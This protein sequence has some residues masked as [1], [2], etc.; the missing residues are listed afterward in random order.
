MSMAKDESLEKAMAK[1]IEVWPTERLVPYSQ[2]A[3]THSDEQISQLVASIREFGFTNP[4]LVDSEDG[5]IAGHGR[6]LAA[7]YLGLVNV[8]VVVLD[9]LT[10]EQKRAY[11]LADNKLALNAGWDEELLSFELSAL[12]GENFDLSLLG[13]SE[14]ELASLLADAD[15]LEEMP[16]MSDADRE[17]FQQ[18]SFTLHDDQA[19]IVKEAMHKAKEMGDFTGS[20]NENS[21]GNALAR[22]AELFLSWGNDHGIS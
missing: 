13:W 12:K 21:N 2:N 1:R 10:E 19:A 22:I 5:I 9:H 18:M 3:R 14:A 7:K 17:P 6:L 4:I 20:L 8:P 16:D 11:I 15:G